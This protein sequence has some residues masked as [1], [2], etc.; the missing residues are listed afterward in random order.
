MAEELP[1]ASLL[2]SIPPTSYASLR[3]TTPAIRSV[4]DAVLDDRVG[5]DDALLES[6]YLELNTHGYADVYHAY[7]RKRPLLSSREYSGILGRVGHLDLPSTANYIFG[8]LSATSFGSTILANYELSD[9][10]LRAFHVADKSDSWLRGQL[11]EEQLERYH[12]L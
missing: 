1:V 10:F 4:V 12:E 11:T 9:T 8:L 5:S 3:S 2:Y 7:L 6:V